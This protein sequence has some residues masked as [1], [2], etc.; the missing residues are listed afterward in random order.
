MLVRVGRS[1]R[2]GKAKAGW[3][4]VLTWNIGIMDNSLGYIVIIS[5]G[6]HL[7]RFSDATLR[8]FPQYNNIVLTYVGIG[9]KNENLI[10]CSERNIQHE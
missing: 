2:N 7:P 9:F 8:G 10:A 4:A 6:N 3:I 1:M 5:L